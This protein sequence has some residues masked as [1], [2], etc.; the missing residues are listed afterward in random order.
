MGRSIPDL[1]P[2]PMS[3]VQS[4]AVEPD[5]RILVGGFFT[6]INGVGRSRIA[7]LNTNGSVDLTFDPGLGCV[8]DR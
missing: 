2:C 1:I 6:A 4:L 8:G 3:W 5:D 7:R